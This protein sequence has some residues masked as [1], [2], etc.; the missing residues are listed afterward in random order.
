MHRIIVLLIFWRNIFLAY[1][2][3]S[4]QNLDT[5]L[6]YQQPKEFN[7]GNKS[8]TTNL[9]PQ[10]KIFTSNADQRD[11]KL[12]SG[13]NASDPG[14]LEHNGQGG[15]NSLSSERAPNQGLEVKIQARYVS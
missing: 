14:E 9:I 15:H 10:K 5:R 4:F 13:G 3:V 1:V 11:L 12:G 7:L 2:C 6:S 8:P